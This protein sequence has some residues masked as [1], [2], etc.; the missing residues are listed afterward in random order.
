[1]NETAEIIQH[2]LELAE[3]R[4]EEHGVPYAGV[5][6]PLEA[7]KLRE[8]DPKHIKII[9]V[10]SRAEWELVG[11]IPETVQ[12]EWQ[13]YPGW[14]N[15]SHFLT[16]LEKHVNDDDVL[17]FICRTGARS[18]NA[19]TFVTQ[20]GFTRCYNIAEG[21]EGDKNQANQRCSVNGWRAS[22]LPWHN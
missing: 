8:A 5:V 9:D 17:L 19:A 18:N 13:T 16:E 12:I 7:Y 21:F 15:N 20:S 22:G 10:R 4:G 1:M 6:T 2:I 14:E 11:Y 3:S